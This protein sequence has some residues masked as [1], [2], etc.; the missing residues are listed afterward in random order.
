MNSRSFFDRKVVAV[1]DSGHAIGEDHPLARYTDAEVS[2]VFY[3]RDSGFSLR[4]IAEKMD[5]PLRTVRG[6]L[7]LSRRNS[8]IADFR[9]VRRKN[10][11]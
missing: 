5:M 7:N 3:L 10:N 1:S 4:Q 8:S 9:I 2:A 6:Y 11:G